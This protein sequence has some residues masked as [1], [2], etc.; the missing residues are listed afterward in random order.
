VRFT[1]L[2]GRLR[3]VFHLC[4]TCDSPQRQDPSCPS[5][6]WATLSCGATGGSGALCVLCQH[7]F[8]LHKHRFRLHKHAYRSGAAGF[9]LH[10]YV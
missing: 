7:R 6:Q 2:I 8:R 9:V 1:Y 3:Q 10:T 4:F 5:L